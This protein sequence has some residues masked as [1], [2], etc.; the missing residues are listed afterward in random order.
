MLVGVVHIA[1]AGCVPEEQAISTASTTS[2]I[3]TLPRCPEWGCDTNAATIGDG[4]IFD[5][6]ELSGLP[7]AGGVRIEGAALG[8]GTE[9]QLDVEG[10]R[11]VALDLVEP[12]RRYAGPQ[13]RGM[14]IRLMYAKDASVP[15]EKIELQVNPV[16]AEND[17][18]ITFWE[19]EPHEVESYDI[20]ARRASRPPPKPGDFDILI[21]KGDLLESR[22]DWPAAR[23]HSALVYEGDHFDAWSR[24][25]SPP[26]PGTF[27]LACAGT[28]MAKMHLLRHTAAS[29][30]IPRPAVS[31]P[32]P[33]TIEERIAMLKMITAD[34]CGTG[35]SF[36]VDGQPLRWHD[37]TGWPQRDL[38]LGEMA[39]IEAIWGREGAWCLNTPRRYE[40]WQV[41]EACSIP[42]CTAGDVEKWWLRGHVISANPPPPPPS[43]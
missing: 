11:L 9:V 29:N 3:G 21:C 36:T 32:Y 42:E 18:R 22:I 35:Q 33:T 17:P 40:R 8:D 1:L 7:N 13:L 23:I 15:E 10:D 37:N 34:Y 43:P 31:N 16:T 24:T 41:A 39:S 2:G 38:N 20:A 5:E 6:L 28:A 12:S 14:I 4:I 25:V 19:G 26:V 30:Y 27:N